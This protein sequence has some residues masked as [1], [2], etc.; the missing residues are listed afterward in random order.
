MKAIITATEISNICVYHSACSLVYEHLDREEWMALS[1]D[2][3]LNLKHLTDWDYQ[4]FI[5]IN[6]EEVISTDR[7]TGDVV[8]H[9]SID[10]FIQLCIEAAKK[11][12]F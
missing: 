6:D 12:D 4:D 9:E 5:V 3:R 2:S 8:A 10:K 7:L 1:E 11:Y